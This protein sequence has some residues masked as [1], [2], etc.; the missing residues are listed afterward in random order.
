MAYSTMPEKRNPDDVII[1]KERDINA[2]ITTVFEV[3]E[4]IQAFVELEEGVK[5]VTIT[6]DIKQGKG[7]KSHWVLE[8]LTT[9]ETW[10]LD[11]E[12]IYYDKPNQYAYV[13]Y[14]GGKDYSGVHTLTENP[15]GTTHHMFN[16][17][18]YFDIDV[19]VYDGVVGGMVDNVKKW[20]EER[21]RK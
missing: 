6:S 21:A 20:A 15:D 2:P 11:E 16:E 10:E 9:H 18:F 13:G 8:D 1:S 19:G 7:M 14:A 3:I 17:A 4:D 12:I 5:S